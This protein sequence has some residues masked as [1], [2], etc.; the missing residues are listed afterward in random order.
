LRFAIVGGPSGGCDGGKNGGA[1]RDPA[2][3]IEDPAAGGGDGLIG[4]PGVMGAC[5]VGG[6]MTEGSRGRGGDGR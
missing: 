5:G 6:P 3:G 1:V 4:I 2:G